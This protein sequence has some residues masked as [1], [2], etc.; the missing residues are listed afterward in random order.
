MS[1]L[2]RLCTVI[3]LL[4]AGISADTSLAEELS[5]PIR[6]GIIG[7]SWVA[8]NRFDPYLLNACRSIDLSVSIMSRGQNGAVSRDIKNSLVTDLLSGSSEDRAQR[9]AFDY[10]L[11]LAGVNNILTHSG[12]DRYSADMVAVVQKINTYGAIPI[13]LEIPRFGWAVEPSLSVWEW[14]KRKTRRFLLERNCGDPISTYRSALRNAL[15]SKSDL[16]IL[17]INPD[18]LIPAY[19]SNPDIYSNPYHLNTNGYHKLAELIVDH[20]IAHTASEKKHSHE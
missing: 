13:V 1:R 15:Q 8:E 2:C 14:C 18:P 7:D 19:Q 16:K 11:V 3:V 10:I 9:S 12:R 4:F 6:I 5:P 17:L 20:L